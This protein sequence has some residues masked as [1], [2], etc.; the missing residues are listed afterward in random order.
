[1]LWDIIRLDLLF[2]VLKRRALDIY[3]IRSYIMRVCVHLYNAELAIDLHW[4][5]AT[6]LS[7]CA[8]PCIH[9]FKLFLQQ[10]YRKHF[11]KIRDK[12]CS[13]AFFSSLHSLQQFLF[14]NVNL[15]V[16]FVSVQSALSLI[17]CILNAVIPIISVS[18]FLADASA[19]VAKVLDVMHAAMQQ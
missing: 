19:S 8:C 17:L 4:K 14:E 2:C 5:W 10:K 16:P 9:T 11:R 18:A 6:R 15:F 3:I 7:K 1:M 13:T 12:N